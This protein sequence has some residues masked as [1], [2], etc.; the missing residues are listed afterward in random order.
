MVNLVDKYLPTYLNYRLDGLDCGA[1]SI[2]PRYDGYSLLNL[3]AS[4]CRWLGAP[5]FGT[6]PLA[7]EILDLWEGPF[8][9]VILVLVD[10]LG[11]QLFQDALKR[12]E[13]GQEG[14][15]AWT[16][17]MKDASLAPLTS[18]VPSTTSAALTT[19]WTGRSPAAHGVV[20]YEVFLKEFGM[21]ANMILHA[22][23]TSVGDVGGLR[24]S[25][26]QPEGFLPVATLG[27]HLV[28]NGIRAYA[29]QHNAIAR[30]GLSTMLLPEVDVYPYR[31][32]V[33]L[34][35]SLNE[36]LETRQG[37]RTYAYVYM[38]EIDE[39]SHRYGPDNP[40]VRME[41]D[42]I[43]R[44]FDWFVSKARSRSRHNT[45]L[46]VTGD[47]GQISTPKMPEYDLRNYPDLTACLSMLPSG[48]SRLAY[49]FLRQGQESRFRALIQEFWG[50]QFCILPSIDGLQRGLFGN[51][52]VY[53]R[54]AERLG[55]FS[56]I[57]QGNAYWWWA[58]KENPLL[59]RHG[60]MTPQE[61]LVPLF[62]LPL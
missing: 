52:G 54:T 8:E 11:L 18:V 53:T 38:G 61:M 21:I 9:Q 25:G 56:I 43:S 10:A 17:L 5:H 24:R 59:G 46:L 20:G 13:S 12:G 34:W 23:A 28:E 26:F 41:L 57:S 47:H 50:D 15:N 22:A 29:F 14:A 19:L 4:I 55:D 7:P 58:E 51:D 1:G 30:S 2:H 33:D 31:T 35:Y 37:K 60:G 62:G 49:S 39:L 32:Q 27:P 6:S 36:L 48:E 16:R 42:N 3:P 44:L 45:L 40:R